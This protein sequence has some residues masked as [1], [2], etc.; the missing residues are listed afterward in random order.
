VPIGT[1]NPGGV[2]REGGPVLGRALVVSEFGR[3]AHDDCFEVEGKLVARVC[4]RRFDHSR[5]TCVSLGCRID[6]PALRGQ[7]RDRDQLGVR[8]D[9]ALERGEVEL[10]GNVDADDVAYAF[11]F[12]MKS[13]P[14]AISVAAVSSAPIPAVRGTAG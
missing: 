12:W 13:E 9:R 14:F 1:S 10:P 8:T 11:G 7:V 4:S 6:E 5:D 2:E 3:A